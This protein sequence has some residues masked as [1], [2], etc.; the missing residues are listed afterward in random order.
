MSALGRLLTRQE[1]VESRHCVASFARCGIV[2]LCS[3]GGNIR[4]I[5]VLVVALG[6]VAAQAGAADRKQSASFRKFDLAGAPWGV[7]T[8]MPCAEARQHLIEHGMMPFDFGL[9]VERA[10][11]QK[12]RRDV[13]HAVLVAPG[14][15]KT[16]PNVIGCTERAT[17]WCDYAYQRKA[18]GRIF[19]LQ[20]QGHDKADCVVN[21]MFFAASR[22]KA[23][24]QP[25]PTDIYGDWKHPVELPLSALQR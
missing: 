21:R 22:R 19:V 17:A 8:E 18:D 15:Y 25:R 5:L 24:S 12:P 13:A 16:F 10:R 14:D 11:R 3:F 20:T 2:H 9:G 23:H 1:W 7:A 4:S 6:C